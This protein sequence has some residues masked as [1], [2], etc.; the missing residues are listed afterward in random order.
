MR[1]SD[2]PSQASPLQPLALQVRRVAGA[3]VGRP[4][5]LGVIQQELAAAKEG[6]LAGV[7][8]EG[9]PGIGKTRLLLAT[10]ELASAGG[11]TVIA[12]AADEE[13]RGPFL[14]A[15]SI[16]GSPEVAMAASG[17]A[18]AAALERSMGA[19]EGREEPGLES[20]PSDRR[21]LR[22]LDLAAVAI[23]SLLAER[24]VAL[25][26]DDM[27][28]ADDDSLRLLR[29]VVRTST[30][31]PLFVMLAIRPE[32]LAFVTEAVNLLAD[33]DRQGAVR[34]LGLSRFTQV[35]TAEFLR[36]VL[37]GKVD[38]S[39][40]ATMHSQAE[41]VPFIVEELGRSYRDAAMIQEIDGTWT[42]AKNVERL[43]PSSVRTLISRRASQLPEESRT[44]M[45][46]A[47]VLGREFS[48]KDLQA[49]RVHLGEPEAS[50]E[51]LDELLAPAAATGLLVHSPE[52]SPADYRFAHEQV[53]DF[54][55]AGLTPA[56]RRAIHAAVVDLLLVG[57]PA[58]QTLPLLAHHA[59]AAGNA[60]VC[61]RFSIQASRNALAASAP[62]EVLRVVDLALPTASASKDRLTL[63]QARDEALEMLRRPTDRLQGLAEVA[64]LAEA[65]GDAVLE[66]EVQLRRAAAF[67]QAE[68]W[69]QAA[70]LARR[71]RERAAEKEDRR[72]ELA[73]SLELGQAL[74]R[75]TLGESFSPPENEVDIDGAEAAYQE[76]LRLAEELEDEAGQAAAL[77]ELGVIVL[78]RIRS[79]FVERVLSGE[80][81]PLMRRV[82]A[83]EPLDSVMESLPV[84]PLYKEAQAR[85]ERAL[86]LFEKT[87]DRRGAMS[88]V[89]AMAYVN[90]APD[91]HMGAGAGRHIEEIRRLASRM[92]TMT[93][94]SERAM[95]EAQ[96]LYGAHMFARAKVVPDLALSR[97][98]EAYRHARVMGDPA[99]EFLAAGGTA[100]AHLDVGDVEAARGW[101]DRAAAAATASPTPFRARQL[102]LWRGVWNGAAGD[103]AAMRAHL[104]RAVHLATEQGRAPAR[105]EALALLALESARLGAAAGDDELLGVAERAAR[106]AKEQADLL[107][108]H[109]PWG[110][111]AD[112]ALARVAV[113]RGQAEAAAE[114]ARS[115][116]QAF[117]A[118]LSED[119]HLEILLP[120]AEALAAGDGQD[121]EQIRTLL[122]FTLSL[123][124]QRTVDEEVRAR[125]LRAPTGRELVER[126]GGIEGLA[127][128]PAETHGHPVD[129][130]DRELLGLLL[131]GLSNREIAERLDLEPAA[132]G[133]RLAEMF[134]RIGASS[135]AD[136]TA[137]AFRERVV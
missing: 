29:Y 97:G 73:A 132:V 26:I 28:W 8:V 74:L 57:E 13:I 48:L 135:Q 69:E 52:G 53:R 136:A 25:L 15:R 124:A 108:G 10:S 3:V 46:E 67:R 27:Q 58:P 7:S 71:V 12:V 2:A 4:I 59:R 131:E 105:C 86:E 121:A 111:Q 62:E 31:T 117:M 95:A 23:R 90:W 80:H 84:A 1:M 79:W 6:R 37:G 38:P 21:L 120:A 32:E 113:A 36:Q 92:D 76:A 55:T 11:F 122:Q 72:T 101:L 134:A 100:L 39:S 42:L 54:A 24:P 47:A 109:P 87:G 60:A 77:R 44:A 93:K 110:A 56:R 130:S 96:M 63:L 75:T 9:E 18:A 40:A 45:A 43:V 91:I 107:P 41:G 33:L 81:V 127:L 125:W 104:E 61:V 64:A 49:L 65:M 116:L 68:E 22:T 88:S 14:L 103:A 114:A 35:E 20:L 85:L 118:S 106:E 66:M 30:A 16:L 137:F 99:L 98:E 5:E 83:G 17:T 82:A 50:V 102:E 94:E 128:R 51:A 123:A 78:G 112:A 70:D 133:R 119:A 115:A 89:I 19:L 129:E 126:A 34:R